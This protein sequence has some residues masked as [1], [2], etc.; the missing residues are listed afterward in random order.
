[1]RENIDIV[2][3]VSF[4]HNRNAKR[5]L[6]NFLLL[7]LGQGWE[8]MRQKSICTFFTMRLLFTTLTVGKLLAIRFTKLVDFLDQS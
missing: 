6:G 5:K 8:N 7:R 4:R 1:M 2:P 3:G